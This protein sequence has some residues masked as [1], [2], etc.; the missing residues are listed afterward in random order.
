MTSLS[1]KFKKSCFDSFRQDDNSYHLN[2]TVKLY[3]NDRCLSVFCTDMPDLM[4][5][6][7][8]DAKIIDRK[9]VETIL[10]TAL[11][12]FSPINPD[13]ITLYKPDEDTPM[14]D[15]HLHPGEKTYTAVIRAKKA[16]VIHLPSAPKK[17]F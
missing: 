8:T 11:Q 4:H 15:S 6:S 14:Q 9:Q 16:P 1:R 2:L 5:V 7:I 3:D 10:G 13:S 17:P 12:Y